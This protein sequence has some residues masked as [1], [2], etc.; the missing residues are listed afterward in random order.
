[1]TTVLDATQ[2]EAANID[3]HIS[4]NKSHLFIPP[5]SIGSADSRTS[6]PSVHFLQE[7]LRIASILAMIDSINDKILL[8][9]SREWTPSARVLA[10]C[11]VATSGTPGF[12]KPVAIGTTVRDFSQQTAIT[13]FQ[14]RALP[15]QFDAISQQRPFAPSC[16]SSP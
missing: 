5:Y 7:I 1:M 14:S 9:G 15:A 6:S 10:T 4:T 2:I 11:H 3:N 12:E 8:L 16:P 13:R